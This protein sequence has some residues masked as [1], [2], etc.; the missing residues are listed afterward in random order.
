MTA[1]SLTLAIFT[2]SVESA[3]PAAIVASPETLLNIASS[4]LEKVIFFSVPLSE[5]IKWSS[6]WCSP[7]PPRAFKASMSTPPLPLTKVDFFTFFKLF[8]SSE[9]TISNS[10][11]SCTELFSDWLFIDELAKEVWVT[12][13]EASLA[14][15]TPLS[16][17]WTV[18][19]LI[20]IVVSSTF[21][22]M[23]LLVWFLTRPSPAA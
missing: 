9:S 21:T 16:L 13:L 11:L 2:A 14:L 17:I 15:V 19:E 12:E 23:F 22:S 8:E 3:P 7:V 5:K 4:K 6:V 20:S 10:S 1:I 18:S